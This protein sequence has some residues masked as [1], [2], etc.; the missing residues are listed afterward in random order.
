MDPATRALLVSEGFVTG[1]VV[2][3]IALGLALVGSRFMSRPAPI[4]GVL[5]GG[6]IVL[7]LAIA[8]P[9]P[10]GFAAGVVGLAMA[11]G[12]WR[13]QPWAAGTIGVFGAV[14]LALAVPETSSSLTRWLAVAAAPIAW[15]VADFDDRYSA[16]A[17][18]IPLTVVA[19]LAM[20]VTVPDTERAIVA[21]G[22]ALP[23]LLAGW[24]LRAARLGAAGGAAVVGA[25][26]WLA[27]VEGIGRPGSVIGALAALGL[28][29]AEPAVRA[30]RSAPR[31]TLSALLKSSPGS[32]VVLVVQGLAALYAARVAG[33]RSSAVAAAL[34]ALPALVLVGGWAGWP[35]R[36]DGE[37]Y[38][39]AGTC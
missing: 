13:I 2:G 35:G 28:L 32:F 9:V 39:P 37:G 16:S 3:A 7:A 1:L 29:I 24:P 20:L 6:G 30:L 5:L 22:V 17:I 14:V 38:D 23:M 26:V 34:L 25:F 10:I 19:F 33:L 15:L 11:G 18:S 36:C 8:G 12:L 21:I 31:T 27:F 4:G